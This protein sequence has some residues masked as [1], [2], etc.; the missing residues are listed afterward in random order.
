MMSITILS[1]EYHLIEPAETIRILPESSKIPQNYFERTLQPKTIKI[2]DIYI[3]IYNIY[4]Y[5]YIYMKL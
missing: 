4:I 1:R 2:D 3:Y 5:I